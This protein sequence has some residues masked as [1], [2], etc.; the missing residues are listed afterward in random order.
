MV[1]Q[2]K[3]TRKKKE[4]GSPVVSEKFAEIRAQRVFD[5]KPKTENQTKA[6]KLLKEKK[7]T[8]LRGVAVRAKVIWLV[9]MPPT[10]I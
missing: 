3:V 4:G 5:L 1:T 2:R 10:S 6:L 9:F 7:V 8:V